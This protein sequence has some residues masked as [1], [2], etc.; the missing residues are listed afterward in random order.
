VAKFL[1]DLD[2]LAKELADKLKTEAISVR[3][4]ADD[5]GVSAATLSRLLRGTDA[6]NIPD[7]ESLVRAV[8]WLGRTLSDFEAGQRPAISTLTDVEL[9]LR[10]LPD[11]STQDKDA[12]VGIVRA[13]HDTFRVRS[14]QS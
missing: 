4:A 3:S 1:F 10:A 6:P 13:A 9:H 11:L 7:T 5:I 2:R 12:L 14:T 8:N